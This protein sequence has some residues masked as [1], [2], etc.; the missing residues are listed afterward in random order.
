MDAELAALR[1]QLGATELSRYA[2]MKNNHRRFVAFF[3]MLGMKQAMLRNVDEAWGALCDINAAKKRIYEI[4]IEVKDTNQIIK[5][6]VQTFFFSD[7][8]IIFTYSDE[9]EDLYSI[10]TLSSELFSNALHRC[11]PLRGA[12]A[13][14]KFYF[15][16]EEY[17]FLGKPLITAYKLGE[18]CQ[19]LGIVVDDSVAKMA[20]KLAI[21]EIIIQWNVPLKKNK[22]QRLYVINWPWIFRNNFTIRP[23]SLEAFYR[24]FEPLF[25][26]FNELPEKAKIKYKNTVTFINSIL[27]N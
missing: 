25:G 9:P 11:V 14:G 15:N 22:V 20:E 5:D 27:D 4:A 10:L 3:D 2:K 6:R 21:N 18:A 26:P 19:W 8:V 1:L 24:A 23:I 7:T 16:L 12:I 13:H 17:L